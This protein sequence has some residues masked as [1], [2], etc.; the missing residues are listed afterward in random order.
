M[1]YENA[2]KKTKNISSGNIDKY[3]KS[4]NTLLEHSEDTSPDNINSSLKSSPIFNYEQ[5]I[6]IFENTKPISNSKYDKVRWRYNVYSKDFI[7]MALN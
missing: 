3:L 4:F 7:F 5:S 1:L 2:I 6:C